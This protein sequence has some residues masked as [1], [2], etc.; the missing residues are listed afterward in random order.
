[1][2]F[3]EESFKYNL[4]INPFKPLAVVVTYNDGKNYHQIGVPVDESETMQ[5]V[6]LNKIHPLIVKIKEQLTRDSK[7]RFRLPIPKE[8]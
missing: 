2:I 1:M 7:V 5:E 3:K 6:I 4:E 8:E